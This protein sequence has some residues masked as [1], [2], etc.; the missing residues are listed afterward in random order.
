M[1]KAI[2]TVLTTIVVLLGVGMMVGGIITR[3]NGAVVVGL[4]VAAVATQQWI[5]IRRQRGEG[6]KPSQDR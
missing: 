4:I 3:K 6:A 1:T 2:R 5:A